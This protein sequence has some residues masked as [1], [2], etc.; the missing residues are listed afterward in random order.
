MFIAVSTCLSLV[1]VATPFIH[2]GRQRK[3][4]GG[5]KP[6]SQEVSKT[7]NRIAKTGIV[8]NTRCIAELLQGDSSVLARL[9]D[10]L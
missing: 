7:K 9:R 1:A 4:G 3:E 2:V 10:A 8:K 5:Q 6:G